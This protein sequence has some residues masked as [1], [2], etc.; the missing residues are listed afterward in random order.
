MAPVSTRSAVV[1]VDGSLEKL[2]LVGIPFRDC[3][4]ESD[5]DMYMKIE[6]EQL[7]HFGCEIK[8]CVLRKNI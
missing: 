4:G 5:K 3:A 6:I 1:V 8:V 2:V 7:I